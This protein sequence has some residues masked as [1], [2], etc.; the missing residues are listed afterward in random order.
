MTGDSARVGPDIGTIAA[1]IATIAIDGQPPGATYYQL[2]SA[3]SSAH[4]LPQMIRHGA[5][6]WPAPRQSDIPPAVIGHRGW[7]STGGLDPTHHHQTSATIGEGWTCR[8]QP[9]ETIDIPPGASEGW[10]WHQTS[11]QHHLHLANSVGPHMARESTD[12]RSGAV[13]KV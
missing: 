7:I 10:P 13:L 2:L 6:G 3:S 4:L 11:D 5:S 9:I 1:T 12:P 8:A